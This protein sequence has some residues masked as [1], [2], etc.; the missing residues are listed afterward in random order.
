MSRKSSESLSLDSA[1]RAAEL[2]GRLDRLARSSARAGDMN[3]A[4]WEA[5]R[6]LARANRFSRTPAAVAEYF[7][8]TRGTVSQTLIALEEKGYVVKRASVRDRRSLDLALT[9]AGETA[10]A[11][12]ALPEFAAML[13]AGTDATGLADRLAEALGGVLAKRGGKPFGACK[14]CRHFRTDAKPGPYRCA[15]LEERLSAEDAELICVEQA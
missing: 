6:Y 10:L 2:I 3:P 8:S 12:D 7:G 1:R 9:P 15:L 13:A 11:H 5:L 4:Q 14:T